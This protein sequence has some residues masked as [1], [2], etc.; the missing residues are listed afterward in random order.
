MSS[1]MLNAISSLYQ[2]SLNT[3]DLSLK[4]FT[5]GFIS[6]LKCMF[7]NDINIDKIYQHMQL[8]YSSFLVEFQQ[9]QMQMFNENEN[10]LQNNR[11][12]FEKML[13]KLNV[14][15]QNIYFS[16]IDYD[17]L[18]S[19]LFSFLK[20][21][22]IHLYNFYTKMLRDGR[23][24]IRR[25]NKTDNIL[26]IQCN[27]ENGFFSFISQDDGCYY[28]YI[29]KFNNIKDLSI[30][31]HELGHAY[32]SYLNNYSITTC[33]KPDVVIK[34]EIPARTME[35]LFINFLLDNNYLGFANILQRTFDNNMIYDRVNLGTL[36]SY[37]YS[38]ADFVSHEFANLINHKISLEDFDNGIFNS[39]YIDIMLDTRKKYE[40]SY[41]KSYRR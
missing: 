39:S 28:I 16:Y 31:I 11:S 22:S 21:V 35:L 38:F 6:D 13:P 8:Y 30:L 29:N 7:P 34:E 17:T 33:K 24:L 27:E 15:Y 23:I 40:K 32:Y 9:I 1:E 4:Y 20:S 36:D 14:Q 12:F 2:K 18:V 26:S 41:Q 5:N 37:K 3:D 19:L 25:K 10:F